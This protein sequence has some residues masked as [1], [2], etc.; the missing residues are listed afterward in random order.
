MKNILNNNISSII[1]YIVSP[2]ADAV[3][4]RIVGHWIYKDS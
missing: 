4:C 1:S 2:A 3:I